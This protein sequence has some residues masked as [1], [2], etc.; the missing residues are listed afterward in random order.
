MILW[1]STALDLTPNIAKYFEMGLD[2]ARP[3]TKHSEVFQN[4]FRLRST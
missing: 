4:G 2:C 1:V 3:D